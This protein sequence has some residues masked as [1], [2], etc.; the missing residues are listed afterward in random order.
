MVC[1]MAVHRLLLFPRRRLCRFTPAVLMNTEDL[2]ET[3]GEGNA[4]CSVLRPSPSPQ[5]SLWHQHGQ[6]WQLWRVLKNSRWIKIEHRRFINNDIIRFGLKCHNWLIIVTSPSF[7]ACTYAHIKTK[8]AMTAHPK[9]DADLMKLS[10]V[11]SCVQWS[12]KTYE[13]LDS[14]NDTE[15]PK[16]QQYIYYPSIIGFKENKYCP[17]SG[18]LFHRF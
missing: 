15:N 8:P 14:Y 13:L 12:E 7:S 1:F 5:G 6:I 3:S 17:G 16:N 18:N 2:P 9:K 10:R 11:A 4:H